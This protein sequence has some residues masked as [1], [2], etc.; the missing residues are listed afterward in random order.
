MFSYPMQVR[1]YE[2]DLQGVVNNAVYQNYLEHARHEYLLSMGVDFAKQTE[3]GIH[4]MVIKA[5]IEY[6]NS[7]KPGDSFTVHV[8]LERLSKIRYLF[9]QE[10]YRCRDEHLMLKSE[11]VGVALNEK[12]FPIPF[13]PFEDALNEQAKRLN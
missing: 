5:E 4:L 3:Q 1:D 10:I 8:R 6:K 11:F 13:E 9:K 2:C 12:G 7:L